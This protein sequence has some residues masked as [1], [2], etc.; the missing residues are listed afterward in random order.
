MKNIIFF[1]TFALRLGMINK[2]ARHIE[3]T[4]HP[5]HYEN[6]VYCIC[7]QIQHATKIRLIKYGARSFAPY[8]LTSKGFYGFYRQLDIGKRSIRH[9]TVPKVKDKPFSSAHAL[10]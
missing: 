5:A 2:K 1:F 3:Q 4:R 8:R 10:K 9:D 6:N 7:G